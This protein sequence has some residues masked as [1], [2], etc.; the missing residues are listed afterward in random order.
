LIGHNIVGTSSYETNLANGTHY[1]YWVTA[2]NEAGESAPSARASATVVDT[3]AHFVKLDTSTMGNWRDTYGAEGYNV[4]GDTSAGNPHYRTGLTVTPG[5]HNSGV[6]AASTLNPSALQSTVAGAPTRIAAA[7]SQTSWTVNVNAPG[8][9]LVTLYLL[10]YTN[11]GY[12]ETITVKD[13]VTGA[14][15]DTR[16]ASAFQT[17]AYYQWNVNGNVNITLTSTAGH[18]AVLSGIFFGGPSG[19]KSPTAP[20]TLAAVAGASTVG[21]TWTASTGATSYDILRGMSTGAESTTPIAMGVKSTSF[22]DTHVTA[23][24]TYFYKVVGVNA[25]AGS[26]A[27]N[28]ATAGVN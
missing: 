28:E 4:I 21:L 10:D 2:L 26:V 8:G 9:H 19:A 16:S 1:A 20:S 3:T 6:W 14:V 25:Y 18:W 13:A 15:L 17:G 7:W 23:G 5:A 12:A 11:A 27:S 24:A 22:T